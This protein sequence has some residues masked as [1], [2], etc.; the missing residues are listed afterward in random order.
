MRH[1]V[2][3]GCLGSFP[4]RDEWDN[5]NRF[6]CCACRV[7]LCVC[8]CKETLLQMLSPCLYLVRSCKGNLAS[9]TF[10]VDNVRIAHS[11]KYLAFTNP[12]SNAEVFMNNWCTKSFHFV[13][14]QL[15]SG[16]LAHSYSTDSS[17]NHLGTVSQVVW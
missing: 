8:I 17:Q 16:Q 9:Y 5:T 15:F 10:F 12:I 2:F 6:L 11:P 3:L 14:V 13:P 1:G 4:D 7:D